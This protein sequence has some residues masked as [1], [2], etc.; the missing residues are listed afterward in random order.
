MLYICEF[1][2]NFFPLPNIKLCILYITYSSFVI[3]I[4]RYDKQ[5]KGITLYVCTKYTV[6]VSE[7]EC[8]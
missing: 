1:N 4:Y 2:Q 7:C 3:F 6:C 8:E 5:L